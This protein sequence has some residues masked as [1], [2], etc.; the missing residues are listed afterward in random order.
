MVRMSC[1][2]P[3]VFSVVAFDEALDAFIKA[4]KETAQNIEQNREQ[5][6]SFWRSKVNE[7]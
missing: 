6:L 1:E 2:R 3:A 5:I 4:N 7:A